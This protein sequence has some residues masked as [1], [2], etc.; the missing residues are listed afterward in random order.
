MIEDKDYLL[1]K[2][3]ES[4]AYFKE[5]DKDWVEPTVPIIIPA[6]TVDAPISFLDPEGW[7]LGGSQ[8]L[9]EVE[10]FTGKVEM[11]VDGLIAA[12]SLNMWYAND[13][14]GKS[15][16]ALESA[17]EQ[18]HNLPVFGHL[19]IVGGRKNIVY[20]VG[21]RHQ[22]EPLQR[23]KIMS[24]KYK[25]DFKNFH[26][27]GKFQGYNLANEKNHLICLG[28]L[29]DIANGQFGGKIDHIYFDPLNALCTGDMK[30][31]VVVASIRMFLSLVMNR[32]G[33]AVTFTH[34]ENRG[35]RNKKGKRE[36]MDFYGNKFLSTMS[37]SV[38]HI[39]EKHKGTIFVKEKDSYQ[40]IYSPIPLNFDSEFFLSIMDEEHTPVTKTTTILKHINELF[41]LGK[42]FTKHDLEKF[43]EGIDMDV[44]PSLFN[45]IILAQVH[46][47]KI[48]N[49]KAK[50]ANATYRI[51]GL[52]DI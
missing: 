42:T 31:D 37:T 5:Q 15:C 46:A 52:L 23:I 27:T 41:V 48:V 1:K 40:C 16:L 38:I 10:N 26:I 24:E 20:V 8:L 35:Q 36:G 34:H 45:K 3:E 43:T 25:M 28:I 50:G 12:N 17:L 22:N 21:E 14:L 39:K 49:L 6:V 7:S 47:K 29:N 19:D 13:G 2:Q 44:T 9:N 32:F 33:C 51:L 4:A 11:I 18:A 30:E